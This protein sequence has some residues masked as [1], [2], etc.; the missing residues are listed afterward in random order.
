MFKEEM[1]MERRGDG[2]MTHVTSLGFF[3]KRAAENSSQEISLSE[4][5]STSRK[6]SCRVRKGGKWI[7]GYGPVILHE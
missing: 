7:I 5:A 2:S 4:S 1:C 6:M 3:L